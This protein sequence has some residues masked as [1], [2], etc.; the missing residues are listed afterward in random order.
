MGIVLQFKLS[1]ARGQ[2]GQSEEAPSALSDLEQLL[3]SMQA[4]DGALSDIR[5]YLLAEDSRR[6]MAGTPN[7]SGHI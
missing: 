5:S 6:A 4:V 2:S 7:L 3:Q 1:G